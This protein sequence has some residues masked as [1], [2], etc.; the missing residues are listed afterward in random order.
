MDKI[1][2]KIR[3]AKPLGWVLHISEIIAEQ[4]QAH[5]H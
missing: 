3:T 4:V 1:I 5:A 2:K